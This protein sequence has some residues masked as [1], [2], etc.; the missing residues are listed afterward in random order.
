VLL[1]E[2]EFNIQTPPE[3]PL[4]AAL[5]SAY[6]D[7]MQLR[8]SWTQVSNISAAMIHGHPIAVEYVAVEYD[9]WV[10]QCDSELI[11]MFLIQNKEFIPVHILFASWRLQGLLCSDNTVCCTRNPWGP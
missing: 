4:L 1:Q 11:E 8:D 3:D 2:V 5:W 7:E 10:M 9:K 6:T